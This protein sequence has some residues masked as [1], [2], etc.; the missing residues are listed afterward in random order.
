MGFTRMGLRVIDREAGK[1]ISGP[2]P[3]PNNPLAIRVD[4]HRIGNDP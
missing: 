3:K 2:T 1:P 4:A